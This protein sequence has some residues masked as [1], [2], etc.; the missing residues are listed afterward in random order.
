MSR[1][2]K[3]EYSGP[4]TRT[5]L[6]HLTRAL[7]TEIDPELLNHALTHRSYA[8]EVGDGINNERL[9]FLGDAVLGIII[10]EG[11]YRRH[12][13]ENEHV[14]AQMKNAIVSQVAL[15]QAARTISL[16][17][18]IH[19]GKG[20]LM[21][22]GRDKDSILCD[23]VEAVFGAMYLTHG[24]EHCRKVIERFLAPQL[25]AAESGDA[26]R[27]WKT[28]L[29]EI[30]TKRDWGAPMYETE[31]VGPDH[32]RVFQSTVIVNGQPMGTGEGTSKK[33]ATMAAAHEA[34]LALEISGVAFI[35]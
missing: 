6:A 25:Q 11:L 22:G 9:E 8:Y 34:C 27:E 23:T 16:G 10:V 26:W 14:L 12:P 3:R 29:Q 31:H 24:L 5:D 13:E 33:A 32:A 30:C 7:G 4:P 20:E 28:E 2:R 35:D 15:A 21:T 18:F 19:L 17:E 1:S